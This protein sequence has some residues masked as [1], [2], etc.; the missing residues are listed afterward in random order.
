MDNRSDGRF[1]GQREAIHQAVSHADAFDTKR[2]DVPR[3]PGGDFAHVRRV[4]QVMLGEFVGQESER[5]ARAE[6]RHVEVFQNIR[7]RADMVF[8]RVSEYDRFE[9]VSM[10][11]GDSSRRE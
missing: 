5:Q 11:P 7:Q 9:F 2:R 1:D 10:S 6:D 3:R 4:F 8:V